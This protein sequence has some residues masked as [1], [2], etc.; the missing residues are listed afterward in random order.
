MNFAKTVLCAA[1]LVALGLALGACSPPQDRTN[2]YAYLEQD[3]AVKGRTGVLLTALG[4]PEEYEFS[5][6]NKYLNHIFEA[7]FPPLLKLIVMRDRGT[8]LLDPAN[9]TAVEQF[10]PSELMDCF[11][12][13]VNEQGIPYT[14]LPVQWVKPRTSDSHAYGHFLLKGKNGFV[15][16]AER[17]SV[18]IA[19]SYY[20][21][22]PGNIIPFKQQHRALFSD[23]ESLLAEQFPGTPMKTAWSMYPDTI[24]QAIEELLSEKVETIV[25]C[26]LFPVYSNLEEFNSLFVEIGQMVAGRAK[27]VFS[28]FAG[29]YESYRA[30]FVAMARA[31][32]EQLPAAS[33]KLLVLTRHGFPEM[34]GEPWHD[35]APVF[36]DNLLREVEQALSGSNTQVVI[37]DTEFACSEHDPKNL[38]L[39][40]AEAL[41]QGLDQGSDAVVFVLVDFMS[42]NTDT[43]FCAREE[44]L[45]TI[46][47]TYA[48]TVPYS[49]FSVPF[50]TDM[51]YGATRI[52]LS[53]APVG[54]MYR[55]MLARGIFDALST[56]LRA[57]AWPALTVGS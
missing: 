8:V 22:M 9:P 31:E 40:A 1:A 18:K 57:E 13:T 54:D 48:G 32:I 47:F 39:S 15:D 52:I 49:D 33:K 28:P 16:I 34:K 24:A 43:I 23:I 29:V 44:A 41:A 38:R 50:R 25:V 36:Y 37:A 55:P 2:Y 56:V 20:G 10:T 30:P 17:S 7:A 14:Q 21:R 51:R 11:G 12:S 46:G 3:T 4:Q 53:G 35:L 26:N 42:E 19:A 45:E 27:I 5:F 6:Y